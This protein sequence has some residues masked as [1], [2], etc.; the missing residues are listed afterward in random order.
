MIV[1]VVIFAVAVAAEYVVVAVEVVVAIVGPDAPVD[2]Y[3]AAVV[4]AAVVAV[5]YVEFFVEVSSLFLDSLSTLQKSVMIDLMNLMTFL[6]FY[7]QK[8]N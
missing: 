2:A 5:D 3:A 8:K 4:A 6:S 7:I 1:L